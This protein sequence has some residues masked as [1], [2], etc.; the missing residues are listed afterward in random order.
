[1]KNALTSSNWI[2]SVR[3]Q[4]EELLRL[5]NDIIY[6]VYDLK[7][8]FNRLKFSMCENILTCYPNQL[9]NLKWLEENKDITILDINALRKWEV[10]TIFWKEVENN[11]N[12]KL[13]L[14]SSWVIELVKM[15]NQK[16]WEKIHTFTSLRDWWA[17]D[18]LQRTWVAGRNSFDNLNEELE[19]EYSEESPFLLQVD[20]VWTL[21][22][23]DRKNKDDATADLKT[24]VE[25]FLKNKYNLDRNNPEQ[26]EFVKMFE[27]SFRW[28]I[29]YEELWDILKE[30]IAN[31]KID[32]FENEELDSFPGLEKDMKHMEIVDENGKVISSWDYFIYHDEANNTV[33]YRSLREIKIPKW[34][35][36]E[37]QKFNPRQRLFLESQNQVAKTHRLENLEKD[38]L[39]PTMK[40]FAD[41][42]K[43]S[44]IDIL[45][46]SPNKEENSTFERD[47][48][49]RK[50]N[51]IT[52]FSSEIEIRK[53]SIL[54]E[55]KSIFIK[56][57]SKLSNFYKSSPN[58]NLN[59]LNDL[60]LINL[61]NF[62]E[63]KE[64]YKSLDCYWFV[65][66][67]YWI[68][69]NSNSYIDYCRWKINIWDIVWF[70]YLNDKKFTA[71]HYSLYIWNWEYLS[72][73][74]KL[75]ICIMTEKELLKFYGARD[76]WKYS[77]TLKKV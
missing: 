12:T 19:R 69:E 60:I 59:H 27:K 73:L 57:I 63:N 39:V 45:I 20:W 36:I 15:K 37:K 75:D 76:I 46:K 51:K 56:Y 6:W 52:F 18:K 10:K 65:N 32:F 9:A 26:T 66:F 24:S 38:S 29:K 7:D 17:A 53:K 23:P 1:M 33:E 71:V 21:A 44:I 41:K 31:N 77:T 14:L 61:I 8:S 48:F 11:E 2:K 68:N 22:T 58:I 3:E 72:K 49:T 70:W 67:L 74:W 30:I 28:K 43:L 16:G 42:I 25:Y 62:I 40:H 34:L 5:N 64:K 13:T 4:R 47:D 35:D 50:F 54:N 55:N